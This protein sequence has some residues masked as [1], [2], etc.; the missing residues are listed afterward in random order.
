MDPFSLEE[1]A[2]RQEVATVAETQA[3]A[4]VLVAAGK[5]APE[6][7]LLKNLPS[8]VK[9]IAIGNGMDQFSGRP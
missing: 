3:M 9:V 4:T 5:E 6:L 7:E 2:C 1:T 8:N